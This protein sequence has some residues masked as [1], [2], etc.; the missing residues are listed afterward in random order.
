M[1]VLVPALA[2]A[3]VRLVCV[4]V[5]RHRRLLFDH[6]AGAHLRPDAGVLP[7]RHGLRRQQRIHRFQGHPGLRP[8]FRPHARRAA[9]DHRRR[10][11]GQLP[12]LPRD[13][14]IASRARDARDP[15]CGEP[16]PFSRLSRRILQAL[17]LR[18]FRRHRRHR[19]RAVRAADR[20]HQSRASL[21][22]SIRSKSSSGW[23]S[24]D[25]ARS[26]ARSRARCW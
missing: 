13:C 8:A 11:R 22:R 18:V 3:G 17:G 1:M 16:D 7:Q 10:A 19:R 23:R 25:A 15:R 12:G 5:A 14:R 2:G 20:H 6:H 26:T 9:G 24:E 21:R 4:P